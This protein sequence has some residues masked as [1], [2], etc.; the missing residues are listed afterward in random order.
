MLPLGDDVKGKVLPV[1]EGLFQELVWDHILT[2]SP[3]LE[4]STVGR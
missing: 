4:K 1:M 3:F 2:D